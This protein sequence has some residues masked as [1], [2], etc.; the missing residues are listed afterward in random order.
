MNGEKAAAVITDPPYGVGY[1]GKT[2]DALPVHNDGA[3]TLL[4]LLDCRIDHGLRAVR[5]WRLLVCRS[6]RRPAVF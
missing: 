5:G 1:V 2:K 3:D 4:P 6:A